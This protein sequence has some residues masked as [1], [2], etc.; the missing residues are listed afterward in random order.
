M[1]RKNLIQSVTAFLCFIVLLLSSASVVFAGALDEDS[2]IADAYQ[3]SDEA[4]I[5]SDGTESEIMTEM[6]NVYDK[7][8]VS[9][10]IVTTT[11]VGMSDAYDNVIQRYASRIT[12][13]DKV[14]LFIGYKENDHVYQIDSYGDFASEY[15]SNDRL[16]WIQD[17][18]Q[19][20]MTSGSFGSACMTYARELMTYCGRR[21]ILDSLFF[22]S[23]L[24]LGLCAVIALVTVIIM[25]QGMGGQI[26]V[27]GRDYLD[28]KN[29]KVIGSFD[30]FTHR[31]VEEIHHSDSSSSGGGGGGGGGH[32]SSGGRSF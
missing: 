22:N 1:I 30:R 29:S 25:L 13:S 23:L 31:T 15:L 26:T 9:A 7:Y 16:S 24:Q 20:D 21:P 28:K 19:S 18:M 32:S 8:G 4:G 12:A 10:F 14:V 3:I 5:I 17:D 11:E 2:S 6:K 27:S